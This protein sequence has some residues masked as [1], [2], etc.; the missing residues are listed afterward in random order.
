MA[1]A[2]VPRSVSERFAPAERPTFKLLRRAGPYCLWRSKTVAHQV[3]GNTRP[4]RVHY[5]V[6][7]GDEAVAVLMPQVSTAVATFEIIN[8]VVCHG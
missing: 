6:T 3:F 2:V 4:A 7:T 8:R 1:K 5:H